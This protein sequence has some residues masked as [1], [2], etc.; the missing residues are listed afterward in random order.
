MKIVQER[1]SCFVFQ[2][3]MDDDDKQRSFLFFFFLNKKGGMRDEPKTVFL[4]FLCSFY[5]SSPFPLFL[6]FK[7]PS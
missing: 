3:R 2:R 7:V 6:S 4:L 5:V 1:F